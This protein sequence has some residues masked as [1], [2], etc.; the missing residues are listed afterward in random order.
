M[1]EGTA[2]K[3]SSPVIGVLSGS[4][5]VRTL[6]LDETEPSRGTG[7]NDSL[8]VLK[9]L[10]PAISLG[11][12]HI[13]PNYFRQKT[14]RWDLTRCD[15]V[16][17]AISDGDV[18]PKTLDVAKMM[19]KGVKTPIVNRPERLGVTS[20]HELPKRLAGLEGVV[21]PNVLLLR[22]PDRQRV[23]RQVDEAG[24]RFP[25]ILRRSGTHNGEVV[26]VFD[27]VEAMAEIFGDRTNTYYLI[28]FVDVRGADG[29]YRK[30]RFFFVGDQIITRQHIIADEWMIHGRSGRG[31]MAAREDL[32]AESRSALIDGFEALP[33]SV[34][35]ALHGIRE[36]V[37][38]EYAGID[39]C[40][41]DRGEVV[42]FEC[43]ATMGFRPVFNNPATQHNRAALP[44]MLRALRR[45]IESKTGMVV[46]EAG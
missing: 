35:T 45:L 31:V 3:A 19:V 23:Q 38:L 13:T 2:A 34:Q 7:N 14:G 41:T 20:R 43:N 12:M 46:A 9:L 4:D 11:R 40:I 6:V 16:W 37:G 26:G 8:V 39:C 18:N 32:Q 36:R 25:G 29:F 27:S 21:A 24:F 15:L 28:E 10:G 17:N 30:S 44:R 22:N 33:A 1:T 42:V 5:H